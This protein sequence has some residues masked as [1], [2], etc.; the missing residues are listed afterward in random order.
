VTIQ[1]RGFVN[2]SAVMDWVYSHFSAPEAIFVTGVSAGSYG[3]MMYAP[4]LMDH[5]PDSRV[6]QLGDSGAGVITQ[7][8]LEDSFAN[9]G[10]QQNFPE[11]ISEI[12]DADVTKLTLNDVYIEVAKYY[13]D[14]VLSQYNSWPDDT[15]E[16][17]YS[18]MGGDSADWTA[19]MDANIS[20]CEAGAS[21]FRA[22]TVWGSMHGILPYKEFY[23][24]QVN[25][26]RIRDW[27]ADLVSFKEVQDIHCTDCTTPEYYQP[28]Q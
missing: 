3:T 27:I 14:Q 10:A 23:T 15:Q 13:P 25:G 20:A 7:E 18:A 11:W 9:W 21:N 19:M 12:H 17:Y 16:F 2:A 5:Y 26:V 22:Y 6:V 28:P 4:Y 8:F 1:H 24:Y